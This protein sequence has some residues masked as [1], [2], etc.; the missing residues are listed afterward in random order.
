MLHAL[1]YRKF[2]VRHRS[3]LRQMPE[4]DHVLL[5]GRL[6]LGF[7]RRLF[8]GGLFRSFLRRLLCGG[9]FRG[10]LLSR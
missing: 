10:C 7:L 6:C 2:R 1:S 5:G 8:R 4:I 9:L 3:D